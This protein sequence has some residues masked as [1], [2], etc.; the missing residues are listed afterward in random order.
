[1]KVEEKT[2]LRKLLLKAM[3]NA[4]ENPFVLIWIISSEKYECVRIN[5]FESSFHEM[6]LYYLLEYTRKLKSNQKS[7]AICTG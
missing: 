3:R 6:M 1:M 4:C 5:E 7:S 2:K